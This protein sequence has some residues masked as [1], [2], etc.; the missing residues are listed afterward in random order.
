MH[1]RPRL[2]LPFLPALLI[3]TLFV[4]APGVLRAQT[5]E[6]CFGC[7][8][9]V[10]LEAEDGRL[11]GVD[12]AA[13][14][15]SVHGDLDCIDC[16]AQPA[17]YDDIPHYEVYQRVDCA[18]CH[19]EDT[20]SFQASF[21]GVALSHG[22]QG[23]PNCAS[24][25]GIGSDPHRIQPLDMRSAEESCRRCHKSE[26]NRYDTSVH[27]AAAKQGKGSPGCV[28]CHPTHGA[29]FPPS[30]GAVNSLCVSCHKDAME[31]LRRGGHRG[32]EEMLGVISCS[33]CHDVHATHKP[34]LDSGVL[35][36]CNECHI[37]YQRQFEGSVHE[38]LF[39]E[40]R[41][42]CLSC[43]RT[44]LIEDASEREDYGCGRCH[45]D[46]ERE[47]RSSA[48]R[49]ARLRGEEVAATCADC[50]DG[51]RVLAAEN[52]ESPVHHSRIPE[53][54]GKCHTDITVVTTDFVRLPISLPSYEKSIHG[55]GLVNGEH[56]AAC[57]DC[58]GVHNLQSASS[59]TSTI[60]RENLARTCGNC[61]R[62]VAEEYLDSVH[63]RAVG[64]GIKDSPTCTDCHDEHLILAT[65]SPESPVSRTNQASE[66]CARCH[67]DPAMAARYGLPLEVVKSF[68]DSYH[69][70]AIQRGGT[71]VAVC[72]DCHTK[73]DIRSRLDPKSTI[74]PDN[75]VRTCGR[76]HPKA[77]RKFAAS[78]THV[79][80][81]GRMMIHDYVRLVY[82]VLITLVI[83]GMIVHNLIIFLHELRQ[84]Y[85]RK[86]GR[87]AV[88]RMTKSELIQ[89]MILFVTFT[90]LAVSGFA[91]RFPEAWWVKII[92]WLGFNEEGR[93]IFHRIMAFLL[94][95]TSLYH[96][97]YLAAT[98]R[99]RMLLRAILPR[100]NDVREA[101][102]NLGYYIG[103]RKRPPTFG[104]YDYTQKAEYWALIWGT[105]IMGLTGLIL[106]Y[107]TIATSW[108]PAWVV[109]VSE[110]IHF[111]EAI[112][113]VSAIIVWHFFFVIF[114][115]REYPMSWTW[116]TGRMDREEWEQHH[117][118]EV[119]ETGHEPVT[120]PPEESGRE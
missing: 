32:Q 14:A 96:I 10:T 28:S 6:D 55:K 75:V 43:H 118:R 37:G 103:K 57:T 34:H 106:M 110:T 53:M 44:H 65:E 36:A 119:E 112:L 116:I 21:H 72:V 77:N 12:A 66:T 74:H 16:H 51:H 91:L 15:A 82:I 41:M 27:Y 79:L 13:Y 60:A 117:G 48:H 2:P 84:H 86:K 1:L 59:P 58:H 99:G 71:A 17:D 39:A 50:H 92:A 42:N 90:G 63:G 30:V 85:R 29:A 114:L 109:R 3:L 40:G 4:L 7:H 88:L 107:P 87:P 25:H 89:H 73:H 113:A 35:R 94:I 80:A 111:Y 102:A 46:V 52:P 64:H 31:S 68:E 108:L 8:E 101:I 5:A 62:K 93:R 22:K 83:G 81:R 95:G 24:C 67:E 78:Y 56:T 9:D 33:S 54:C 49:I 45:V 100:W 11:V 104:M 47:Y 38:K 98:G 69:G 61:H 76:C 120:L 97:Y 115:P 19:A 18:D 26:T 70:W 23:A 20:R 105:A